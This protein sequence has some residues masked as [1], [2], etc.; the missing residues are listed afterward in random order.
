MR[1]RLSPQSNRLG[2]ALSVRPRV[3]FNEAAAFAAEQRRN[4]SDCW[5]LRPRFNEAAA[6]AAEQPDRRVGRLDGAGS[7]ASMRLRLSPQSNR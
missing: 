7:D 2:A 4:S 5:R 1:L 6:F 3:R